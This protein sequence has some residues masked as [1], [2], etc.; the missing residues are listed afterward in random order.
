M[1]I[2]CVTS[3]LS[4]IVGTYIA[5]EAFRRSGEHLGHEIV[6]ETQGTTGSGPLSQDL[7]ESA[8]GV[9]F[10]VD[11][12]ITW[13]DRFAGKPFLHVDVATAING[14][15][16]LIQ[17]LLGQIQD[18][19]AKRIDVALPVDTTPTRPQNSSKKKGFV[20]KLFGKRR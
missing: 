3:C 4:G 18:G 11:L 16:D 7:I 9:I 17:Q 6:V 15:T 20:A 1:R 5:A 10:A 13:R 19:T 12:E 14:S 8:D 2:V